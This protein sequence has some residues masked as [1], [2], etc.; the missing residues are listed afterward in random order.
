MPNHVHVLSTLG[1]GESLA[2]IVGG[3]KSVSAHRIV[4][5]LG[6]RGPIWQA[7]SYDH[8]VRD[9]REFDRA[10]DYIRNNPIRAGLRDWPW[11]YVK[12]K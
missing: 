8:L 5:L 1:E 12:K 7:E 9:E 2:K 11:V 10:V 4:A 3:W 6:R